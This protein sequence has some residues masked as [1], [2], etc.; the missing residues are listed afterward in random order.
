MPFSHASAAE[1]RGRVSVCG[2][3]GG[4]GGFPQQATPALRLAVCQAR[5]VLAPASLA[6]PEPSK[7]S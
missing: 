3:L 5:V 4:F 1:G 6:R 2:R 7:P